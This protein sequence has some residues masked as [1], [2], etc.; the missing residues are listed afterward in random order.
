[1][2]GA[3]PTQVNTVGLACAASPSTAS[4]SNLNNSTTLHVGVPEL[5]SFIGLSPPSFLWNDTIEGSDFVD[6]V[7]AAYDEV[8]HWKRNLF[9]VPFGKVGKEFVLE[10]SCLFRSYGEKTSLEC[11]ALKTA[12]LFCTLLLQKPHRTASS[13]DFINCLQC[14]LLL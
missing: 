12:M 8:V 9:V 7:T 14:R 10:L 11:I 13:R 1:M 2:L 3:D 4:V 6:R 5:P